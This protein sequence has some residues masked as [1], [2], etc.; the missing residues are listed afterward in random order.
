[1]AELD[2]YEARDVVDAPSSFNTAVITINQK[3]KQRNQTSNIIIT[4]RNLIKRAYRLLFHL[5]QQDQQPSQQLQGVGLALDWFPGPGLVFARS[6][7]V[8]QDTFLD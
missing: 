7:R 8:R 6:G 5:P 1:L 2:A 3:I 4:K